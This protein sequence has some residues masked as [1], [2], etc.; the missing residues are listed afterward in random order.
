[1]KDMMESNPVEMKEEKGKG[2]INHICIDVLDD[3]TFAYNVSTGT[4]N[5][6]RYSYANVKDLLAAVDDDVSSPHLRK[7]KLGSGE[8]FDMLS[9]EFKSKGAGNPG[10]LAAYIGRKK[11]GKARFQS[12]AAKGKPG[13]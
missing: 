5:S 13:Y 3:G 7:P 12:L 8:R 9:R 10:A 4:G 1:M 6:K 2:K 11:Y